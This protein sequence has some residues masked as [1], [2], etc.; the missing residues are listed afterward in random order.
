MDYKKLGIILGIAFVVF[1]LVNQPSEAAGL[2]KNSIAG[3]GHIADK[4][5]LFVKHLSS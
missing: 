1:F 5:A 4:L 2:I 3:V